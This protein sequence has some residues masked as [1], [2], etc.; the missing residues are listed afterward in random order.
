VNAPSQNIIEVGDGGIGGL[1]CRTISQL[2]VLV[3]G[4][5]VLKHAREFAGAEGFSEASDGH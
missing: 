3:L 2:E 5:N 1:I 4:Y